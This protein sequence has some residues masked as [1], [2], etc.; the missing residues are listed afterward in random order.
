MTQPNT[1]IDGETAK[2]FA[3][4][5]FDIVARIKPMLAG[6]GPA[7]QGA[8]LAD[9]VSLWVA[10]HAPVEREPWFDLLCD[11]AWALVAVSEK[12]LFGEAGHPAGRETD[13]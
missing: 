6:H 11:H 1:K 7:L 10:G 3:R 2:E 13:D 8:V 4:E 12:E 5:T 9:L